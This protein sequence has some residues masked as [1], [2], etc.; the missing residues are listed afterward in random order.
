MNSVLFDEKGQAWSR[1]NPEL[2]ARYG[3]HTSDSK[4]ANFLI[5]NV[6]FVECTRNGENCSLRCAPA[7]LKVGTFEAVRNW[8]KAQR[9]RRVSLQ[10][11][12]ETWHYE[13]NASADEI[14]SRVVKLA[15]FLGQRRDRHYFAVSRRLDQIDDLQPLARLFAAWREGAGLKPH[16]QEDLFRDTLHERYVCVSADNNSGELV[17]S[18]IGS[19]L[20]MYHKGWQATAVG[21]PVQHQPD[22]DYA[23]SVADGWRE[24]ILLDE[25]ML[26]DV[27]ARIYDPKD[28]TWRRRQYSRLTLPLETGS[29]RKTLLSV[30]VP[31]PNVDLSLEAVQ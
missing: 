8:L 31:N 23:Q 30:T 4:I 29:S 19:G 10:W 27:D 9:P 3:G 25:P 6:G 1:D 15:G 14:I 28:R 11:F 2:Y 24:A 7:R 20:L 26:S 22:L 21:Q 12:D 13:I 16:A 5:R 18:Q 17:F